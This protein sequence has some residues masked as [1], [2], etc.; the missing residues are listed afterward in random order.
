MVRQPLEPPYSGPYEVVKRSTD[1]V[2]IVKINGKEVAVSTE[3]L[4]PAFLSENPKMTKIERNTLGRGQH[5]NA[6]RE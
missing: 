3:R 6:G 5:T 1:R 2:F 4:K